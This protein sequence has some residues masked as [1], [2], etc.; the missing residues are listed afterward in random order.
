MHTA[1]WPCAQDYESLDFWQV[2]ELQLWW[3]QR[4]PLR[5]YYTGCSCCLR[6]LPIPS[7]QLRKELDIYFFGSFSFPRFLT[8]SNN[9]RSIFSLISPWWGHHLLVDL[10][11]GLFRLDHKGE[12]LV[13]MIITDICVAMYEDVSFHDSKFW[14]ILLDLTLQQFFI[15]AEGQRF[16]TRWIRSQPKSIHDICPNEQQKYS[17]SSPDHIYKYM[18]VPFYM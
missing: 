17:T 6:R 11:H 5:C 15:D 2:L 9:I 14:W 16:P 3:L 12:G 4:R 18:S 8:Y 7:I 10:F 13:D 1:R